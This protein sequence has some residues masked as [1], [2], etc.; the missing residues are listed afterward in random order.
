MSLR[1]ASIVGLA[2]GA[3]F[4]LGGLGFIFLDR[5]TDLT[6]SSKNRQLFA[7]L[8]S[9]SVVASFLLSIVFLKKKVPDYLMGNY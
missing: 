9:I 6:N 4:A 3:L 2:A 1:Y 5:C 7:V 8:G